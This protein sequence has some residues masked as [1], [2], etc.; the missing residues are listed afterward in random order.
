MAPDAALARLTM[1]V[2][3]I[4]GGKDVFFDSAGT[5]ARLAAHVP[6]ADI[7]YLPEAGHFLMGHTAAIDAFLHAARRP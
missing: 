3:A 5:R 1:P 2:M 4:L 7:R 6:H